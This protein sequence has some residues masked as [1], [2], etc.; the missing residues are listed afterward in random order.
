M[1]G[2]QITSHWNVF[3]H[4]SVFSV[5][6]AMNCP[7]GGFTIQ[8]HNELRD[9]TAQLLSEVCHDVVVEPHL[10]PFT[11]ETFQYQSAITTDDAHLDVLACGF[12]GDRSERAYFDVRVFNPLAKSYKNN[13]IPTL[14]SQT[15][16][17]KRRSYDQRVREVEQGS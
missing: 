7:H 4:G 17:L 8:C 10:Q 16:R 14:F 11:G 9:L 6:H 2:S 12:W 15:K 13:A 5:D 3:V 1:V